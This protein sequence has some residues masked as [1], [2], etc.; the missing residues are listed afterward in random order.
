MIRWGELQWGRSGVS[1]EREEFAG[2][3]WVFIIYRRD[4]E[5]ANVDKDGRPMLRDVPRLLPQS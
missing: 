1:I 2:I 3:Q 5:E 4:E